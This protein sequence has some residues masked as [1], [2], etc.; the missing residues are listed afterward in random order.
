LDN[1]QFDNIYC[2]RCE[3]GL[4]LLLPESVELT[5]ASPPYDKIRDYKGYDVDFEV[6]I[7]ELFRVTKSGGVV[8]WIVGDQTNVSESGSSFK[9]VLLFKEK[10]FD[11]Y[12]T[13]IFK[14]KNPPPL[15]H[16]R[17]Q[18]CFDFMFVFSKGKPRV[19]N[20]ILIPCKLAG[21]YQSKNKFRHSTSDSLFLLH[22]S[23]NTKNYKIRDNVWEY[24]VGGKKDKK[25]IQRINSDPFPISL[26][27]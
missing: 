26:V 10:G 23:G 24:S 4:S 16:P 9:Q 15:T 27:I 8:V 19:F 11:L 3:K 2:M 22:K 5:I 6:V 25:I 20:P 18:Q 1:L 14:K 17:Y 7:E 13:M 12:D 21:I